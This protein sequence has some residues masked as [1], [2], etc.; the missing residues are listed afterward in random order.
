MPWP[1]P[2]RLALTGVALT[3]PDAARAVAAPDDT[4]Y[5]AESGGCLVKGTADSS[6]RNTTY[7][8]SVAVPSG[9]QQVAATSGTLRTA[10]DR[11]TTRVDLA[12]VFVGTVE[13][14]LKNGDEVW[15]PATAR[16]RS[17]RQAGSGVRASSARRSSLDAPSAHDL[18][19]RSRRRP[20][21]PGRP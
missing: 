13:V 7:T 6:N 15:A 12:D 18:V 2:R 16:S 20:A 3:T 17:V 19:A 11:V 1:P 4:S 10:S 14:H 9:W 21:L 8:V 5:T